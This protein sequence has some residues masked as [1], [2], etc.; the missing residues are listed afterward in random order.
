M[1]TLAGDHIIDRIR[2][3]DLI[4]DELPNTVVDRRIE[5]GRLPGLPVAFT[6]AHRT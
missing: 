1:Q 6:G 5:N 3:A 4:L 2:Y